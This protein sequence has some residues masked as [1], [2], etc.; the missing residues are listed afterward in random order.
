MTYAIIIDGCEDSTRI[1]LDL[2]IQEYAFLSS[3]AEKINTEADTEPNECKP[4]AQIIK[5]T[6]N[7]LDTNKEANQNDGTIHHK[8]AEKIITILDEIFNKSGYSVHMEGLNIQLD[9]KH[10]T[11]KPVIPHSNA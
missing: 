3:V 6:E 9:D 10:F 7:G 8:S 2:N 1:V 11:I 5:L 4:H